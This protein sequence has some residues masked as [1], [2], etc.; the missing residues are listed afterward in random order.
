MY[1][2]EPVGH[3][4]TNAMY[5]P[6]DTI[7]APVA[8]ARCAIR[9]PSDVGAASRYTSPSAGNVRKPCI[10]LVRNAN[11]TAVPASISQPTLALSRARTVAY[12]AAT[13]SS[14][15]NG[16]GR[17]N[18]N[19]SV[20]TGVSANAAPAISPATCPDV[21]FTAAYSNHTDATPASACGAR[22]VQLENPKT[23]PNRPE[24]HSEAGGLSTV[25]TFPASSEP[26]SH[27]FQLCVA[28]CVAAA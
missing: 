26:N 4:A 7:T 24:S 18:R 15:S 25:T 28:A 27:A 16:S 11:P 19:I 13:S 23:R 6:A 3:S 10:I 1:G 22:T 21:R 20:A 8:A 2:R 14:V 17:L 5:Q 9:L 12:A